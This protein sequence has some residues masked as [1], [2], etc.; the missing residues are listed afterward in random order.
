MITKFTKLHGA[1]N[2]FIVINETGQKH[3]KTKQTIFFLCDRKRGIGADGVIFLSTPS[4]QTTDYDVVMEFYNR[5]GS[6]ADMCGNGLRCTAFFANR[7]MSLPKKLNIKT[8]AGI[9]ATE[10]LDNNRV[11]IQIPVLSDFEEK[12]IDGQ[13][14]F[15]GNTGVP[16]VVISCDNI[17]D[18]DI[19][20]C[21]S[22]FRNHPCFQPQGANVNFIQ[23]KKSDNSFIIRTYERGVEAETSACGT[24]ISAAA[25]C[26]YK[27]FNKKPPLKFIT[28]EKDILEVDFDIA[29]PIKNVN[30]IGP[31][32]GV[33]SG[34][35]VNTLIEHG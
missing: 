18:L 5:D 30:L 22:Y 23:E 12:V 27:I 26:L 20:E 13:T 15:Y 6:R 9:L 19:N 31:V 24:G 4:I 10:I 34:S 14:L 11:K 7:E 32:A 35:T 3:H 25:I 33:F 1:G 29:G 8:D 2:D 21:G 17:D 28:C 16:H